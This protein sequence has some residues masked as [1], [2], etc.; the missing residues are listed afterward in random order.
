MSTTGGGVRVYMGTSLG[1]LGTSSSGVR[2]SGRRDPSATDGPHRSLPQYDRR[3][4]LTFA[5]EG[6]GVRQ[7]EV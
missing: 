3:L 1:R 2:T 6:R 7:G 4:S 5:V